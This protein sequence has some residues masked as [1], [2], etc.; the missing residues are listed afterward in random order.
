MET[1]HKRH[2]KT[3][4]ILYGKTTG[5]RVEF[6]CFSE[7]DSCA[8]EGE[9]LE[10]GE[11]SGCWDI[12]KFSTYRPYKLQYE[13]EFYVTGAIYRMLRT[14]KINADA[15]RTL[16]Q[17]RSKLKADLAKSVVEVWF[18]SYPIREAYGLTATSRSAA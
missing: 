1:K 15:A 6:H 13:K 14:K 12:N 8:F 18:T 7:E 10:T 3:G 9:N 16:L 5:H 11:L 4:Q 2:I 17:T